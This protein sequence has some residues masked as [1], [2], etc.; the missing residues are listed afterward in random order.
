L[1]TCSSLNAPDATEDETRKDVGF[2]GTCGLADGN[3]GFVDEH[4]G[5]GGRFTNLSES[6]TD[7][8]SE[9]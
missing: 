5:V 1:L 3:G 7:S 4:G 9:R 6:D 8:I 2:G